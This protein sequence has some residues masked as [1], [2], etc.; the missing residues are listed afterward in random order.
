LTDN[1]LAVTSFPS[2]MMTYPQKFNLPAKRVFFR[3]LAL[4][5]DK[6]ERYF[7]DASGN[8]FAVVENTP[9]LLKRLKSHPLLKLLKISEVKFAS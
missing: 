8:L 7:E 6:G 2:K 5:K 9:C 1:Y 4:N 3:S